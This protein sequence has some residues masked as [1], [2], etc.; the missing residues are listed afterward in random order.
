M[1]SAEDLASFSALAHEYGLLDSRA[2][3]LLYQAAVEIAKM[4]RAADHYRRHATRRMDLL[5]AVH[6]IDGFR[7]A[8]GRLDAATVVSAFV[9]LGA[10]KVIL[11]ECAPE[12][13]AN[14]GEAAP[15]KKTKEIDLLPLRWVAL[16]TMSCELETVYRGLV[17][18]A[19]KETQQG[20][21]RPSVSD[22]VTFGIECLAALWAMYRPTIP[23]SSSENDG[24]F[25][26]FVVSFFRRVQEHL[27]DQERLNEEADT[28]ACSLTDATVKTGLRR[29][30]EG[31]KPAKR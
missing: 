25:G 20:A 7:K 14:Q 26:W 2:P 27:A 8:L 16:E 9:P 15:T 23:I 5:S 11:A 28:V 3:D 4:I 30:F 21:G 6:H 24:K 10:R 29:F 12:D 22:P 1:L 18:L 13:D 31:E 19:N 17:S